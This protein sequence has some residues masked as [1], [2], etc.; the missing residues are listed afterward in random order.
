MRFQP[1]LLRGAVESGNLMESAYRR[2]KRSIIELDRPPGTTF[3]ERSVSAEFAL[4]KTPVREALARLHRDGLVRP[5]PRAGY[6]VAPVT[7]QDVVEICDMR[8]LLQSQAAALCA[9]RRLAPAEQERLQALC[10]DDDDGQLG[11]PRFDERFR[12]NY[13]FESIIA[14]GSGNT[15]LAR[16]A[17]EVLDDMERIVRLA[18]QID[19]SMPP[20]RIAERVAVVEAIVDGRAA[21]ARAAMSARTTSARREIVEALTSSRAVTSVSITVP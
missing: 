21:D 1:D 7:L 5:M 14:N 20:G 4:S 17:V 8:G 16:A 3:T 13:E 11:G 2:L 12:A 15:R 18:L 6:A 9:E 10:V 19:P